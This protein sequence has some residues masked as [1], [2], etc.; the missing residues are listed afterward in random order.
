MSRFFVYFFVD[1][2]LYLFCYHLI[3]NVVFFVILICINR[4]DNWSIYSIGKMLFD[5]NVG[6]LFK[7]SLYELSSLILVLFKIYV[8]CATAF[9]FKI[10]KKEKR[11]WGQNGVLVVFKTPPIEKSIKTPRI[12]NISVGFQN[13]KLDDI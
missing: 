12:F 8:S 9:L 11:K 5:L 3:S 1:F 6:E 4:L 13:W 7:Y 2:S 10:W